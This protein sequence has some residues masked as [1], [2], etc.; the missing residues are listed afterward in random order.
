MYVMYHHFTN[1][2]FGVE[3]DYQHSVTGMTPLMVAAAR[4]MLTPAEQLINLGA[5]IHLLSLTSHQTAIDVAKFHH[6]AECVE[7]LQ[8]YLYVSVIRNPVNF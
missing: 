7:L 5:T 8:S 6:Q 3:A 2:V 4:G 1:F